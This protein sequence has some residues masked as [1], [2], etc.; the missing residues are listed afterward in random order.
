MRRKSWKKIAAAERALRVAALELAR[1]EGH[2]YWG[3]MW[4]AF[5]AEGHTA[6]TAKVRAAEEALRE[7]GVDP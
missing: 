7:L 2:K 1:I 3:T 5:L 6:A 4:G